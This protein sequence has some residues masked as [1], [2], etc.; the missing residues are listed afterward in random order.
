LKICTLLDKSERREFDVQAN[1]VGF[2]IPDHFVVGYGLD[3]QDFE[4]N[5]PYIG[6]YDT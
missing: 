6:Y 4:R 5:L 1:Y 2:K 3:N